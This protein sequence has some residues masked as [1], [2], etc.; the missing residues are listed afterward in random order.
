MDLSEPEPGGAWAQAAADW[1]CLRA[2]R[3]A[4]GWC[5]V[6]VCPAPACGG[7]HHVVG[8]PGFG[9]AI[10]RIGQDLPPA[11]L[12]ILEKDGPEPA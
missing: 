12:R 9:S 4:V 1:E 8:I 5:S 2:E 11:L 10:L 3:L 6:D 7:P